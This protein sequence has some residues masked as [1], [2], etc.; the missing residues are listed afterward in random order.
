VRLVQEDASDALEAKTKVK[1]FACIRRGAQLPESGSVDKP[2]CRRKLDAFTRQTSNCHLST[3]LF[4]SL[5]DRGPRITDSK[6]FFSH[7]TRPRP[8]A[9]RLLLNQ[10]RQSNFIT[11]KVRPQLVLQSIKNVCS[12]VV[13]FVVTVRARLSYH[14]LTHQKSLF[15]III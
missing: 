6:H 14:Q 10:H 9:A 7:S 15:I 8:F 12:T 11:A 1:T 4:A 2:N 3:A 13:P 5:T